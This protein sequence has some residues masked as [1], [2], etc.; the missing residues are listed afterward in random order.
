LRDVLVIGWGNPIFGDDGFAFRVVEKLRDVGLP[1]GVELKSCSSSPISVAREMLDY[2]KVIIVDTIRT[3][4][5]EE[6][7]VLRVK[8]S[9]LCDSPKIINPHSLS[10]PA[11][12]K[13]FEALHP[14]RVP[15]EVL[16]IG[17]CVSH[18]GIGEELSEEIEARV[19]DVVDLVLKEVGRGR[20]DE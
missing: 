10:L 19:E 11:A 3:S 9:D 20:E 13:I 5:S 15:K 7:K 8:L 14:D 18:P 17:V 16:V 6:G 12:L 1:E 2:K 4:K